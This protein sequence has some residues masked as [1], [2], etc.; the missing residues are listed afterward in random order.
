MQKCDKVHFILMECP[1]EGWESCAC[2]SM[3]TN[4]TDDYDLAIRPYEEVSDV[5]QNV[6]VINLHLFLTHIR[7]QP[8]SQHL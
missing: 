3:G 7:K 8:I 5:L 4:K 1:E 2:C 6:R